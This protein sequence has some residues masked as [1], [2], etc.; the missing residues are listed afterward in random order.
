MYKKLK[1]CQIYIKKQLLKHEKHKNG[2][3][4]FQKKFN[5]RTT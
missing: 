4:Q 3:F 1:R 5:I 2:N